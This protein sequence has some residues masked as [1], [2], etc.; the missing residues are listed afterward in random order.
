ML[1]ES[2]EKVLMAKE[3]KQEGRTAI[4]VITCVH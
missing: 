2:W 3:R 1:K 4:E